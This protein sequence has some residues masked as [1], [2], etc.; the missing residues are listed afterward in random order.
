GLWLYGTAAMLDA[1]AW[2]AIIP[3]EPRPAAPTAALGFGLRGID[4]RLARVRYSRR[5]FSNIAVKVEHIGQE[6][7]GEL[8][9]PLIAGSVTWRQEGRGRLTARLA[10]FA[11]PEAPKEAEA[12]SPPNQDP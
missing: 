10:R 5:E 3:D 1:D 8:D 6:W 4:M 7:R 9:S 11:I 2:T 12:A